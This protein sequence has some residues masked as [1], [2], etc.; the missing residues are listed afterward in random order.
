MSNTKNTF[1]VLLF[2]CF[3]IILSGMAQDKLPAREAFELLK[4][5]YNVTF[6]YIEKDLENILIVVPQEDI[7]LNELIKKLQKNSLLSIKKIGS[8]RIA[9]AVLK[10]NLSICGSVV[11]EDTDE[12]LIGA[13][14][15]TKS[16]KGSVS[17]EEGKF[18]LSD[19]K[20]SDVFT[21]SF[22]GYEE[23]QFDVFAFYS[24]KSDCP[25]IKLKPEQYELN[26]VVVRNLFTTGLN[27]KL[28]GSINFTANKYGI[29]P[30]LVETDVLQM[31]QVLPGVESVSESIADINIRG[32]SHD[33][34]LLLFDGIKMYHSGHFFGLIS[35][36]NSGI[37][38]HVKV[39]KN[40]TSASNT[41]GVSGTINLSSDNEVND[42]FKGVVS[43]N[44]I[45]SN[46]VLKIPIN[47]KIALHISGRRAFTDY[48]K[49]PT[50]DQY[51]ERSFQDSEIATS[52]QNINTNSDFYFYDFSGKLLYDVDDRHK[53]RL[54]F[55][56]VHNKL[57]YSELD[58][59]N[60]DSETKTSSLSQ[61]NFAL[62]VNFT[63][64][65]TPLFTTQLETYYTY[66]DL[67]AFDLN[68]DT[69]QSLLQLNQ[70]IE[71]G[72]KLTTKTKL[73]DNFNWLNGYSY[74]ETGIK[75]ASDL[76]NPTYQIIKKRVQRNHGL[77]SEM[78][79]ASNKLFVRAG[80]RFNYFERL[81]TFLVEPRLNVNQ[82]ISKTLA[83]K[84]EGEFKNQTVTQF[85]DL[86]DDFLG[87]ENR[88]WIASD[89]NVIPVVKSKQIS[90][91]V[92]YKNNDWFIE[93][94][95]YYKYINGLISESQSFVAQ[96][97]YDGFIGYSTAFGVEFLIN[98]SIKNSNIWMSYAY[99]DRNYLF[100]EIS[101]NKFASNFDITHSL[102]LGSSVVLSNHWKLASGIQYRTG[103]PYTQPIEGKETYQE[104]NFT[105]VN[106]SGINVERLPDYLRVDASVSYEIDVK[107]KQLLFSLGLLNVLDKINII[108]RYYIVSE[109]SEDE[110]VQVEKRALGI[111]PNFSISYKF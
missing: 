79:Y 105:R 30:G 54:S 86:N 39:E 49:S 109:E 22:I 111:T 61:D 77:F 11:D 83:L 10:D 62:G 1:F 100:E 91:G 76:V 60:G 23:Q 40:G 107:N 41:D 90:L 99:G 72:I 57:A 37:I 104:G 71:T 66:Y 98:K 44:L 87:V 58:S 89:G 28:D 108:N 97:Q 53:L 70:V 31:V 16:L 48:F 50:Y 6:S 46:A 13:S 51:F 33:Q 84:L 64:Y 73:S 26:E 15:T 38:D 14:I 43:S 4:K 55:L 81:G 63:S 85:V 24:E 19:L 75:N 36:F 96:D 59:T 101:E 29:L 110:A 67:N 5:R 34:N 7:S 102:N 32:G 106:Y 47:S 74:T 65:W 3:G 21:I 42:K 52:E 94:T 12:V 92:D 18:K 27:Q 103:S 25:I 78:T 69:E 68:N 20:N 45:S 93:L 8:D 80:A 56:N 82:K 9:I 17:D 95:P 88:R 35:A 2:F